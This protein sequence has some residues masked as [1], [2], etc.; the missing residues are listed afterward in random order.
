MATIFAVFK[1]Y[2]CRGRGDG[3]SMDGWE[4]E[5][6]GGALRCLRGALFGREDGG[7]AVGRLLWRRGLWLVLVL[8]GIAA[9]T[10]ELSGDLVGVTSVCRGV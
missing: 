7:L 2:P 10:G 9:A 8:T 5:S 1:G 3:A 4:R 6:W